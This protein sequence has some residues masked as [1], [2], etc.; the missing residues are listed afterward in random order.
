MMRVSTGAVWKMPLSARD[1][2][3][4]GVRVLGHRAARFRQQGRMLTELKIG[5]YPDMLTFCI[6]SCR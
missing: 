6:A 4:L 5:I 1:S 2:P 3:S